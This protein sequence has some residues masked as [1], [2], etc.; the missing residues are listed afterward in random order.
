VKLILLGYGRMGKELERLA[1]QKG[2]EVVAKL[3]LEN[4]R[5]G[6]GLEKVEIS[7][8]EIVIEFTWPDAV[9]PNIRH[10]AER[11]LRMVVGTTGWYEHLD[12]ARQIVTET[13][14]KAL[15]SVRR[16]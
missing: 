11:G 3:D 7:G 10:V 8:E 4:N 13:C 1:V 2:H 16:L 14:S 6:A 9:L 12:Q 15:R 5:D